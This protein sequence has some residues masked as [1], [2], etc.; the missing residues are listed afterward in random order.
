[1]C[2][3]QQQ[4]LLIVSLFY[5]TVIGKTQDDY[6]FTINPEFNFLQP[7]V[8]QHK[9][10]QQPFLKEQPEQKQFEFFV[11]PYYK[12]QDGEDCFEQ[13]D[14]V[15]GIED[16]TTYRNCCYG[17]VFG[18]ISTYQLGE[19]SQSKDRR[20]TWP[21]SFS[22]SNRKLLQ[23]FEL[24]IPYDVNYTRTGPVVASDQVVNGTEF[25]LLE[26]QPSI[27][28]GGFELVIEQNDLVMINRTDIY[29]FHSIGRF[30]SQGCTGFL[31]GDRA[32]LTTA[33]CVFDLRTGK[34]Y[35]EDE[36]GYE[37]AFNFSPGINGDNDPFGTIKWVFS[38]I[39]QEFKL[40]F[41]DIEHDFALVVFKD[42]FSELCQVAGVKNC[43]FMNFPVD[44]STQNQ[45]LNVGGYRLDYEDL[46]QEKQERF[47]I[48]KCEQVEVPCDSTTFEHTC[49]TTQGMPGSPLWKAR[50][51]NGV[52]QS[53]VYGV[54]VLPQENVNIAITFNQQNIQ[55]IQRWV[56]EAENI[57]RVNGF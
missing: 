20:G 50:I 13:W 5:L 53:I 15:C 41:G 57:L 8:S 6:I 22:L 25:M 14:P 12:K 43:G 39:P 35:G 29:P 11:C 10:R 1:M 24:T 54:H 2:D 42:S 32:A 28:T 37:D 55:R 19:C 45:S 23:Q 27:N 18:N 40:S 21:E 30:E 26:R 44:C 48:A 7:L 3:S 17:Q 36:P 34:H 9:D 51:K 47:W 33:Y 38:Y 16:N 46:P 52:M 56:A 4:I 31:V 49:D